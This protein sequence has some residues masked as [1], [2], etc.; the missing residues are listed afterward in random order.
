MPLSWGQIL[1]G[2]KP[3]MPIISFGNEGIADCASAGAFR[4]SNIAAAYKIF[5]GLRV[6]PFLQSRNGN[7]IL[8]VMP[9][10]MTFNF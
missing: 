9:P 7:I 5:I 3:Q 10:T 8:A 6:P 2:F 4:F 1:L